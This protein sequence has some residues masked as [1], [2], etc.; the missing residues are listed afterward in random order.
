ML[1]TQKNGGGRFLPPPKVFQDDRYV[2]SPV[3]LKLT[4]TG[5][6]AETLAVPACVAVIV[7]VPSETK[8]TVVPD[9]VHT[10]VVLDAYDTVKP[11]EV[12]PLRV[13]EPVLS[14]WSAIGPNVIV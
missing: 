10:P 13:M 12:D 11:T 9:T 3:T 1:G 14:V 2:Y 4:G 6:A 5:V 8:V 7:H